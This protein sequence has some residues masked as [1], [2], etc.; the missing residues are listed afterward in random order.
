MLKK[1]SKLLY[2]IGFTFLSLVLLSYN[3]YTYAAE[4]DTVEIT[5][6]SNE[7][8][9]N[10]LG[11]EDSTIVDI[12]IYDDLITQQEYKPI[13]INSRAWYDV[14]VNIT[15]SGGPRESWSVGT[16][17]SDYISPGGSISHT[18]TSTQTSTAS[19]TTTLAPVK[20][21]SAQLGFSKSNTQTVTKT[22]S[23]AN[24]TKKGMY[25][26]VHVIYKTY[27]YKVY[28]SPSGDYYGTG[29]F[30]VAT[31]LGVITRSVN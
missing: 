3:T 9:A 2:I 11:L 10:A 21:V 16:I 30:T 13:P 20:E 14:A 26:D 29:S 24:T 17:A 15:Q 31:G 27:D 25:V 18:Y 4:V 1:Q 7:D 22:I 12:Q 28:G 5:S 19:F 23:Q 6:S 8:I